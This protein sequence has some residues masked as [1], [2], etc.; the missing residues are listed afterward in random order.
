LG[1]AAARLA[2]WQEK[3]ALEAPLV[4]AAE[5]G[6]LYRPSIRDAHL[7]ERERLASLAER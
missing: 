7:A 2:D 1:S 6:S 3:L 5:P 4:A